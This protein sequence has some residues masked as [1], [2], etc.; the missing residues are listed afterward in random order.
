MNVRDI[1]A[2]YV[3]GEYHQLIINKS[4]ITY[5]RSMSG[6]HFTADIVASGFVPVDCD[7]FI[8][9]GD[10]LYRGAITEYEFSAGENYAETAFSAVLVEND[11][12]ASILKAMGLSDE[13]IINIAFGNAGD[14]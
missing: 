3:D 5:S 7:I 11:A 4:V 6:R 13:V 12:K 2:V 1:K 8:L 9:L 14:F 10:I